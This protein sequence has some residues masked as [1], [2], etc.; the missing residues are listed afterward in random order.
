MKIFK[1]I[2]MYIITVNIYIY[3]IWIVNWIFLVNG[4]KIYDLTGF[5]RPYTIDVC[6]VVFGDSLE[7]LSISVVCTK[8]NTHLQQILFQSIRWSLH[9]FLSSLYYAGLSPSG[10]LSFEAQ[11]DETQIC[12]P[13]EELIT[14]MKEWETIKDK[15]IKQLTRWKE[16]IAESLDESL[17]RSDRI[18]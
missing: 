2:N 3:N 17:I 11:G 15:W 4:L 16:V 7:D 14:E 1:H 9:V 8:H 13:I 6:Y 12:R 5:I 10:F 18:F